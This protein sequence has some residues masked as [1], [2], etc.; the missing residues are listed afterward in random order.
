MT[1]SIRSPSPTK[2]RT[3]I[4]LGDIETPTTG[5]KINLGE[6]AGTKGNGFAQVDY[7][8]V[9]TKLDEEQYLLNPMTILFPESKVTAI[10]G[11]S[12]SGKTTLLNFVT[13]TLDN[14][15][16]A[17][18]MV[19]LNGK[20]GFVPQED[21]LHGFYTCRSYVDHYSRL[22]GAKDNFANVKHSMD[23]LVSLGMEVHADTIVGDIFRKGLSG[24]QK[25]RLSIALEALSSPE[26]LFLDEPTSGEE[27]IP[28]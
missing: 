23:L 6:G 25:R 8:Q 16:T 9:K 21:R 10:M 7:V 19:H 22:T 2:S 26:T 13:G 18:G 17:E 27:S 24:G 4:N 1:M 20:M 14:G 12:G 15:L 5:D 3:S 11:P 28:M